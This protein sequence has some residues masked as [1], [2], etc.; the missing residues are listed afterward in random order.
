MPAR[1]LKVYPPNTEDI[2]NETE[3]RLAIAL[4]Q[5]EEPTLVIFNEKRYMFDAYIIVQCARSKTAVVKSALGKEWLE[6]INLQA[7]LDAREEMIGLQGSDAL[8]ALL[9]HYPYLPLTYEFPLNSKLLV[10][11]RQ[12][13]TKDNMQMFIRA[14]SNI[15]FED[16]LYAANC[17]HKVQPYDHHPW[18][19]TCAAK[20]N[21]FNCPQ[22][23]YI[24]L[25]MSQAAITDRIAEINRIR[26]KNADPNKDNPRP[27]KRLDDFYQTQLQ[28]DLSH[29][30]VQLRKSQPLPNYTD[31]NHSFCVP[32]TIYP[33]YMTIERAIQFRKTASESAIRDAINLQ[34]EC[35]LNFYQHLLDRQA[36]IPL[37]VRR[38]SY[39][40]PVTIMTD[41]TALGGWQSRE[42]II[43]PPK[44]DPSKFLDPSKAI[45][46]I[47]L[48]F[49]GSPYAN[50]MTLP[51]DRSH[52]LPQIPS[53][54]ANF[55]NNAVGTISQKSQ[56][57][58]KINRFIVN[59]V[60]ENRPY[61][62]D[63]N[64]IVPSSNLDATNS[65]ISIY[66]QMP[67]TDRDGYVPKPSNRCFITVNEA[68]RL[69][70]L[71]RVLCKDA[72]YE[73][74]YTM[75][76]CR[77][78]RSIEAP[79]QQSHDP[80]TLNEGVV[81]SLLHHHEKR[82]DALAEAFA[83]ILIVRRRD[84]AQRAF[85]KDEPEKVTE[86]MCQVLDDVPGNLLQDPE[87]NLTPK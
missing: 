63:I 39:S 20:V 82:M 14:Y 43:I 45:D 78:K 4:L 72:E 73:D 36:P 15:Y 35:A 70:T 51:K 61:E 10:T 75:S 29:W 17:G 76:A 13:P 68:L 16:A 9:Q 8:Q 30:P 31:E 81:Q 60:Q 55:Y 66:P 19:P 38:S 46:A 24:C 5:S 37:I 56:M 54:S 50:S 80:I 40:R 33:F 26:A 22:D 42:L 69:D 49:K 79:H 1:V 57:Y 48:L 53:G 32:S 59:L 28:T 85:Q 18:C 21:C 25:S 47:G 3:K 77:T 34:K 2:E 74:E 84:N 83:I 87:A 12:K 67:V 6:P 7:A 44:F 86:L 71:L 41:S 27:A 65:F 62:L 11:K 52:E 23:C 64:P 58:V